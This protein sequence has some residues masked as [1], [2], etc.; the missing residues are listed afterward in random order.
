MNLLREYSA[1]HNLAASCDAMS[2]PQQRAYD[3]RLGA[4]PRNISTDA[5]LNEDQSKCER[6]GNGISRR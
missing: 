2:A 5:S 4:W 6:A 3:Q 1:L